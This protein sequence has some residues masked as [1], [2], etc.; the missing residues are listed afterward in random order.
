M[1]LLDRNLLR[2]ALAAALALGLAGAPAAL[3]QSG[4]AVVTGKIVDAD[5]G[6]LPRRH[7]LARQQHA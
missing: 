1:K 6:A 7:H 2:L 3:A 4:A 5:G